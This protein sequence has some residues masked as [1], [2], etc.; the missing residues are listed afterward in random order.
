MN[1]EN[2]FKLTADIVLLAH[3]GVHSWFRPQIST[4][5]LYCCSSRPVV[6]SSPDINDQYST[7][8]IN[9]TFNIGESSPY[10]ISPFEPDL[11]SGTILVPFLAKLEIKLFYI[12]AVTSILNEIQTKDND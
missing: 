12:F 11:I 3:D 7:K 2:G 9:I 10:K 8:C 6:D 4:S 1:Y 5:Q